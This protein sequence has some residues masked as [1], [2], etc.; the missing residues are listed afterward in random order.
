MKKLKKRRLPKRPPAPRKATGKPGFVRI[1]SGSHRS[2]RLPILEAPGLRP[3]GDRSREILFNWLQ[4]WLPG[5]QVLD[6]Y[7]GTGALGLEAA[8]RGAA[9]VVLVENNPRVEEN[10]RGTINEMDFPNSEVVNNTAL[11]FLDFCG[12]DWDLVFLD[13]PFSLNQLDEVSL[14]AAEKIRPGGFLYREYAE[15]NTPVTIP[16]PWELYRQKKV[17]QVILELWRKPHES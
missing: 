13:P 5:A 12:E 8:S 3:T 4:P 6:A 7:A 15:G 14:K 9:K 10:L 1:I 2:R 17:G 11:R 16:E